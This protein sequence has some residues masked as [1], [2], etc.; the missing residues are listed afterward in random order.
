MIITVSHEVGI[1][2][3]SMNH[4]L[5]IKQPLIDYQRTK[6]QAINRSSSEPQ[7]LFE[8]SPALANSCH[9]LPAHLAQAPWPLLGAWD[10]A[11]GSGGGFVPSNHCL[12]KGFDLPKGATA[13][14]FMV[15]ES[16]EMVKDF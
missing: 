8:A 11:N 6:N 9:A 4:E 10:G 5:S 14:V 12:P 16:Q 13:V 1:K 7:D 2:E 3:P 15:V